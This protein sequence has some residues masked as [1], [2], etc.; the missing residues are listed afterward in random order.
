MSE[1]PPL[2]P[3]PRIGI[4]ANLEEA[5]WGVWDQEAALLPISYIRAIQRAGGLALIIPPDAGLVKHPDEVLELLDGLILSGGADIDPAAYGA[6]RDP[7]TG[8]TVPE[9]DALET[10]LARRALELDLP[11][12]GICRG[13]QVLNVACGGTLHQHLPHLLGHEHHRRTSGSFRDSDHPV[14]LRAGSLAERAAGERFHSTLSHHH[15]G[16]DVLGEGLQITGHSTLDDLPEAI[17]APA[18]SFVLGV[19][20]HPEADPASKVVS[21]LVQAAAERLS[22]RLTPAG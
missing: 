13:M 18:A 14:Q 17:E 5:R 16:I 3:R 4:S 11:L 20:W 19:Q 22:R 15:Q 1:S 7:E 6:A 10:A 21:A 2:T 12:L 9:R 8:R